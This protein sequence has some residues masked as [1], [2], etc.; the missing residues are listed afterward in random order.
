MKKLT[1]QQAMQA[2]TNETIYARLLREPSGDVGFY[3]PRF[4][5]AQEPHLRD[6]VYIVARGHGTFMCHGE[7]APFA[8]GDAF[9]VARGT[10]HR[11]ENFSDDFATWVVFMGPAPGG[12]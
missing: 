3:H 4:N 12:N 8:P 10:E 7:R 9:F 5:D 1:L 11:F 6:E 2:V